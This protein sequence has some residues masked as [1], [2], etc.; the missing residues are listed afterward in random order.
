MATMSGQI[1]NGYL[2][3]EEIGRGG[4]GVVF[5]AQ[6]L[7]VDRPV[8]IKFLNAQKADDKKSVARFLREAR[9]SGKLAHPNVVT[10]YDAGQSEGMYYIVME[11]VEGP[12]ARSRIRDAGPFSEEETLAIG[13]Q[14]A[15]ALRFAHSRG[16]LHRDV[17]P[18][19]F[20]IDGRGHVRL[21]DL[22]LARFVT[23][24]NSTELTQDGTT[25]GTPAYMS[26]EQCKASGVDARS[27]LYS[28]GASMYTMA[29][30]K[31]P[32]EGPGPGAVIARV[33][34]EPPAP[35]R[36]VNPRLSPPFAQLIEKMMAKD[37]AQ[38]FA[39]AEDALRA[40][41]KCKTASRDFLQKGQRISADVSHGAGNV[42]RKLGLRIKPMLFGAMCA[43]VFLIV[44]GNASRRAREHNN[45]TNP[46]PTATD[47]LSA[48]ITAIATATATSTASAS[49]TAT[50]TEVSASSETGRSTGVQDIKPPN[51]TTSTTSDAREEQAQQLYQQAVKAWQAHDREQMMLKINTLAIDYADTQFVK[52]HRKEIGELASK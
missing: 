36:Q 3:Q 21:A 15:E 46:S 51:W 20:L 2:I 6:Q 17:K 16:V 7:S 8:A 9:A 14:I 19:N 11:L 23:G 40:I 30:G 13:A 12:S 27:D 38:R 41:E 4:M 28:L 31:A 49:G 34:S 24:S 39:T 50:G 10:V 48:T 29:A 35:I 44:L 32:F 52:L 47:E 18:D 33:L 26:P 1:V 22:G 43:L 37:P 45:A 25:L 5:K 42:T